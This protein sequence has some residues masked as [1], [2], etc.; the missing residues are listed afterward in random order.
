MAP[1][2]HRRWLHVLR[3]GGALLA[4]AAK[5]PTVPGTANAITSYEEAR[6]FCESVGYPV[7]LK[8]A[9]GGGGRGMRVRWT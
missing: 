4:A 6:E 1:G 3:P 8:A 2:A 5:V 7:I 9:F